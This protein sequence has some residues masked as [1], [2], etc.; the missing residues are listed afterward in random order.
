MF[1]CHGEDSMYGR[2]DNIHKASKL[3]PK[4]KADETLKE[5]REE[6]LIT[7]FVD[8]MF[9]YITYSIKV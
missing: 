1:L 7:E 5:L 3:W 2:T 6:N 9:I 4:Q 8:K